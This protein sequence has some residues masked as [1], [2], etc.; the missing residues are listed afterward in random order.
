MRDAARL[1]IFLI[2]C[3]LALLF[4]EMQVRRAA[5]TRYICLGLIWVTVVGMCLWLAYGA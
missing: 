2:V 3:S 1:A 4:A 5:N